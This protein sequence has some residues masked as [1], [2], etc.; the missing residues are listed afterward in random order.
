MNFLWPAFLG[1]LAALSVPLWLHLLKRTS[2]KLTPF[3]SLDLLGR[4]AVRQYRRQLFRKNL[5]LL[6]RCLAIA[7]IVFA[8]ARP[9]WPLEHSEN[10]RAV[11]VAVD[12]SASMLAQGRREAV[13][14]WLV[15]QLAK[16]RPPDQLGVLMLHPT[17]SWL[18][19]LS[20]DLEAAKTVLKR[21]PQGYESSDYRPGLDV[22]AARLALA[23][24]QRKEILL[25]GDSQQA[26]WLKA[27]FQRSLP[28]GIHL[29]TPA[30]PAAPKRQ[31]ALVAL[32]ARRGP[33]N[34]LRFEAHVFNGG[35]QEEEREITFFA[36]DQRLGS[37]S[38]RLAPGK[39]AKIHAEFPY[40]RNQEAL[41]LRASLSADDQPADDHV[42]VALPSVSDRRVMVSPPPAPSDTDYLQHA[43]LSLS[44]ASQTLTEI[45]QH[46]FPEIGTPWNPTSV[47]LLRG[48]HPF[49]PQ[50]VRQ[51]DDFL[52]AGGSAWI[53]C[54]GSPEQEAW[55]KK[56]DVHL[57][58]L[59]LAN[60]Q[61]THLR[62]L[63]LQ[64]PLLAPFANHSLL[65][66]LTIRFQQGWSLR[67]PAVEV[68]AQWADRTPAMVEFY[69]GKGRILATGFNESR[70]SSNFPVEAAW[71]PFVHQGILWLS[72][73]QTQQPQG[74]RVSE[75]LALPG[76]GTWSALDTPRPVVS[77]QG[78]GS[79]TP[80]TPG[81]Y[82]FTDESVVRYFA[83]N[84]SPEESDL[85]PWPTPSDFKHLEVEETEPAETERQ[86]TPSPKDPT[87][88]EERDTW[89]WLL[90]LALIL[91]VLEMGIS[92][93]TYP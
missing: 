6:L 32:N 71:L 84:L 46:P 66:L 18:V 65:P 2:R 72:E 11:I 8:F 33:G 60:S 74:S 3:P 92:N 27:N 7:G 52:E 26:A 77:Q 19:P 34:H 29:L 5:V 12:N 73:N 88:V 10:N 44:T 13:E 68:L 93:R 63:A 61:R 82:S 1:A 48:P 4:Q 15:P 22:A 37:V 70:G 17:P 57:S 51:L 41:A 58:A 43:L 28:G 45:H 64:H 49:S 81:L 35:A 83:V 50:H 76:A 24:A 42:Y 91:L 90:L 87:L 31:A 38:A 9:Y 79:I 25:A 40:S 80:T 85:S 62:D 55:F 20:Y 47:A 30:V 86:P 54:D 69:V 67:G 89:W 53:F 75:P 78:N 21:L 59:P 14:A 56:Q 16:L 36:H 39:T 23:T